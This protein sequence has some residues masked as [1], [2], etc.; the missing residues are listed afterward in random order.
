MLQNL[1]S[2]TFPTNAC[3]QFALYA[4]NLLTPP[5]YLANRLLLDKWY[6]IDD[7]ADTIRVR[8]AQCLLR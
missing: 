6:C 3:D 8:P 7:T 1:K 5:G 2:F 4:N